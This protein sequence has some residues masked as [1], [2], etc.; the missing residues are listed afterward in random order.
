M[1]LTII[2]S[3]TAVF[4]NKRHAPSLLLEASNKLLLFDCGWGCGVNLLKAGVDIQKIDHIFI[5]H[6]HADH[7]GNLP[8][9]LQSILVSGYFYPPTKRIKPLYLHGYQ[10]FKKDLD[11]LL[12]IMS[13][14]Y[15]KVKLPFKLKVFEYKNNKRKVDGININSSEV[16][17][18][19]K[20]FKT[21]AYRISIK[22]KVFAYSGD[23]GYDI[24]LIPIAKNADLAVLE[25]SLGPVFYKNWGTKPNHLT[26]YECGLLAKKANIK[27]LALIHIFDGFGSNK[28]IEKDVH[29]NYPGKLYIGSDL[30]RINF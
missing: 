18:V 12:K 5:T 28:E 13:P 1:K 17:H 19:P 21:V 11:N 6:P 25:M 15:K 4:T 9:L 29:Q 8:N 2:G 16:H 30:Q 14:E 23:L 7:M 22:N 26:P 10:G 3:G 24:R 27:R 20:L